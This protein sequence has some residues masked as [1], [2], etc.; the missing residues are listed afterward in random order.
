M[1]G[2]AVALQSLLID[3]MSEDMKKYLLL[4]VVAVVLIGGCGKKEEKVTDAPQPSLMKPGNPLE[5]SVPPPPLPAPDVSKGAPTDL[6]KP[7]QNND[8]SSPAFKGGGTTSDKDA[9]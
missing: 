5:G 9:R 6:P 4:A 2:P 1:A 7:G 3:R 8:H